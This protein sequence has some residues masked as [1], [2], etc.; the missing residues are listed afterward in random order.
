MESIAMFGVDEVSKFHVD[1]D[2]FYT[3]RA[4]SSE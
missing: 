3:V 1:W 4:R 2:N